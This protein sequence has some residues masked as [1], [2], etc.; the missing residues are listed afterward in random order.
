MSLVF[1]NTTTKNGI[2]QRIE[3][4]C[5]FNDGD[6]S[7]NTLR[8]A[9][10]TGDIN[11]A[12]DY[13]LAMIFEEGGTWQFD[14]SNHSTNYPII[15]TNLISGQRDYSFTVVIMVTKIS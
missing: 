5:G 1:S 11:V 4:Y 8:L 3:R 6:I 14:D 7:G 13:T 10:F 9:Q 2:I 12:L 15:T